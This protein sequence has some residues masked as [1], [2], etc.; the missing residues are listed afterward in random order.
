M[1]NKQSPLLSVKNLNVSFDG[2]SEGLFK[3][4]KKIHVLHD[5]GFTMER[6]EILGLVGESG[7]GKSTL[8]K[9]IL[10]IIKNYEGTVECNANC[11]QMVFQ[12]P[13][14]SLNPAKKVG[15][16]L[17]EPLRNRTELTK[18][19]R[20]AEVIAMLE[21]VGLEEKYA[22]H[23][24]RELSGGQRQRVAIAAALMLKP[25]LLIADEPVS[26]LDVTI[27]AQIME[28]L[29]KLH[30]EMNLSILFISHDLR[31]VYQMS[32]RVMIMQKGR[33]VEL[34]DVEEVYENPKEEY[35][36]QLLT[37]AGIIEELEELEELEQK[38]N[39][40]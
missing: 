16:I 33:I 24:P 32:D 12:D 1:P 23:Y 37:A 5:I 38:N 27:Q 22:E 14:G 9:T 28:L 4:K 39:I 8:A 10:N 30:K 7:C 15:W 3:E 36:R 29:L 18:E 21:R 34:G 2:K 17:E 13:F 40:F 6:G 35:T 25:E 19:E 26:A 20:R 11:P 31:V